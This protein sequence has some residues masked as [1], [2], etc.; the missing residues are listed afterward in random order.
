MRS[1]TDNHR[2]ARALLGRLAIVLGIAFAAWLVVDMAKFGWWCRYYS[3]QAKLGPQALSFPS[4]E[5]E[6][7]VVLTGDHSRIPRALELLRVRSSP[8]LIISGTKK[9]T[10]LTELVN[11]QGASAAVN[12]HELWKKIVLESRSSSTIENA[13]ESAK[14]LAARKV[15]RVILVTSDYHMHRSVAIFRAIAPGYD[16]HEY[17]VA[18]EVAELSFSPDARTFTA[19]WKLW[20]EYWKYFLFRFASPRHNAPSGS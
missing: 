14:L 2:P 15:T 1:L 12:I 4:G 6:A 8:L 9:G 5:G 11:Q 7:I 13:Q 20:I 3:A 18:S 17:P 16:Y 19:L 10:R